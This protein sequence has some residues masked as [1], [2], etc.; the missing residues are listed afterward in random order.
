MSSSSLE[1]LVS[2]V[3]LVE[4]AL[5]HSGRAFEAP[6]AFPLRGILVVLGEIR[7]RLTAA[8]DAELSSETAIDLPSEYSRRGDLE[9]G[10]GAPSRAEAARMADTRAAVSRAEVSRAAEMT[11][12]EANRGENGRQDMPVRPERRETSDTRSAPA[13]PIAR[14]GRGLA[15]RIQ[16][17][18]IGKQGIDNQGPGSG[19]VREISLPGEPNAGE[20][21]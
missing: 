19:S 8:R 1:E 6:N 12:T 18:P 17:S 3:D 10:V 16:M 15:S 11:R 2:L 20:S 14:T 4:H 5:V 13:A 9:S 7:G 21:Q